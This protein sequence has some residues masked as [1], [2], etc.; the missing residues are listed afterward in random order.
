MKMTVKVPGICA[1]L[2]LSLLSPMPNPVSGTWSIVATDKKTGQVGGAGATCRVD[3]PGESVFE[4]F[5]FVREVGSFVAQAG[6]DNP[7]DNDDVEDA[8]K[9]GK[10]PS[11]IVADGSFVDDGDQIAVVDLKG[12]ADASE[13]SKC[14]LDFYDVQGRIKKNDITYSVQGNRLSSQN[15]VTNAEKYFKKT[16]K[17][18]KTSKNKKGK[19]KGNK[20]KNSKNR[21]SKKGGSKKG[22]KKKKKPKC[23]NELVDRL[24]RGLEAGAKGKEGD[25]RCTNVDDKIPATSAYLYV[26][27]PGDATIK[28][29]HIPCSSY[30]TMYS[31]LNSA[32]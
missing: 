20:R 21:G 10:T 30:G 5:G 3:G 6:S 26:D 22:G 19:T 14:E 1:L 2:L 25:S 11:Q 8:L 28:L 12:N 15:V 16:C 31:G 13:C 4:D 9:D 24:M 17:K 23:C 29:S 18:G 7:G 27:R 32:L